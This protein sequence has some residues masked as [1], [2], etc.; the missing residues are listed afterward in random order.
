MFTP[1]DVLLVSAVVTMSLIAPEG[2]WT[3]ACPTVIPRSRFSAILFSE[4]A[5]YC[6][7]LKSNW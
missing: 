3:T 1:W 4:F 7:V 6:P 2:G 5:T